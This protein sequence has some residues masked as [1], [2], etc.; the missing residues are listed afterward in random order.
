MTNRCNLRCVY[1]YN[2][3]FREN[4]STVDELNLDDICR[5]PTRR[6]PSAKRVVFTGGEPLLRRDCLDAA[7]YARSVSLTTSCLTNGTL[8]TSMADG[9]AD[10]FD[11]VIVSLDSWRVEE[12]E[13]LRPGGKTKAIVA[14]IEKLGRS[15]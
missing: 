1:C 6:R 8:I 3:V 14:G 9:I 5:V 7:R 11:Q 10:A 13:M 4:A 15:R 2:A 12:Q